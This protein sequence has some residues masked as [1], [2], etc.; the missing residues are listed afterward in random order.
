MSF[1]WTTFLACAETLAQ[2][3]DEAAKRSAISRAYYAAY[4]V[5]RVFLQ[6]KPPPGSDSHK[7][8]WDAAMND[9]RREVQSL[10][11]KGERLKARRKNADYEGTF[12][13]LN[14]NTNDT[15]E[16]ARKIIQTVEG[17]KKKPGE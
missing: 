10:G 3:Q 9:S 7:L 5:V 6:V 1:D 13:D 11:R 2:V 17:L 4:N 12:N 8:V 16:G 14:W 15:I